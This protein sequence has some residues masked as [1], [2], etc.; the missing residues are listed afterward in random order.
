MDISIIVWS[1]LVGAFVL[2]MAVKSIA[3]IVRFIS[4]TQPLISIG[5][6]KDEF[7]IPG[8]DI[9]SEIPEADADEES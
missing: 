8:D 6:E 7:F 5:K 9:D 3:M 4:H 2:M 1:I